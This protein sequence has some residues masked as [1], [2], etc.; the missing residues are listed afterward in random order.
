MCCSTII[1]H[2]TKKRCVVHYTGNTSSQGVVGGKSAR[3]FGANYNVSALVEQYNILPPFVDWLKVRVQHV[4]RADEVLQDN[5]VQYSCPPERYATSHREM[6]AFRMHLRVRSS[7][8]KLVTRDSCVAAT[9]TEQLRWGICN[10]RLIERTTEHVGYIQEILEL[11]Y[12]NHYTTVLLCKWI[13]AARDAR[14][15]SIERDRYG[16]SVANF[17]HMDNRAHPNSFAF[18]LHCQ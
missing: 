8:C 9:F 12:Q 16:F 17:K 2:N 3:H 7:K 15:P 10:G 14:F 18:S 6:H 11:D 1:E 13:R 4:Q 5:V